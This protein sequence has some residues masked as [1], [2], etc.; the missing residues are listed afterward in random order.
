MLAIL[1]DTLTRRSIQIMD[2]HKPT[3]TSQD[4]AVIITKY[5][6]GDVVEYIDLGG[7]P[8]STFK[9]TTRLKT[10]VVRVYGQGQSSLEHITLEHEVLAHLEKFDF[11]SPRLISAKDGQTLQ[12][13]KDYWVCAA[14]YIPGVT[15]DKV[16]RTTKMARNV[17]HLITDYEK[18][19]L[20]INV[21]IPRDETFIKRGEY[22]LN[23]LPP[24]L[25]SRNWKMDIS[26]VDYQWERSSKF[27]IDNA[28]LLRS[29]IIHADIWPPNMLCIGEQI[30]GLVDFDDC[31]YGALIIDLALAL[32]EF[33]MFDDVV[34]DDNLAKELIAG[35]IQN[36][37]VIT[38]L[39][40]N[41]IFD[42]MEM[43]CAMWLA[44]NVIESPIYEEADIYLQRLN[45]FRDDSYKNML[46]IKIQNF[47][48]EVAT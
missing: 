6:Y 7:I 9:V 3:I 21:K 10:I 28:S 17:G 44:Y 13:W 32:M 47:I 38:S 16:K 15:A 41:A 31:C 24:A 34:M 23:S 19:M 37:G 18:A 12:Q 30:V 42:A 48:D 27:F 45:M 36:G 39:E 29:N 8:N 35:Y 11:P 33:S 14:E 5:Q 22:A 26:N 20:S 2:F 40:R 43:A 1:L 4:L 25:A 46:S